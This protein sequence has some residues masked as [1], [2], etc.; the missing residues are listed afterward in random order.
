[1]GRQPSRCA[2]G[3]SGAL[4]GGRRAVHD[5]DAQIVLG[6][7]RTSPAVDGGSAVRGD[8]VLEFRGPRVFA[9]LVLRCESR[10]VELDDTFFL[11]ILR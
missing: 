6:G 5:P 3:A 9:D 1:M 4:A 11:A 7:H 8:P 2:I 10:A